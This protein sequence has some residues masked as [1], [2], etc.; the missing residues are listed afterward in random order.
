MSDVEKN[1]VVEEKFSVGGRP[2]SGGHKAMLDVNLS[3]HTE[4]P[5]DKE[6]AAKF[7]EALTSFLNT[8]LPSSSGDV[9]IN[10]SQKK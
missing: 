6:N 5:L 9:S 7:V 2:G 4:V 3:F 1:Q 8:I 10:T